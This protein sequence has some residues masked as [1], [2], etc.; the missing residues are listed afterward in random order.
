M[1]SARILRAYRSSS[2][3]ASMAAARSERAVTRLSP[4]EVVEV[5]SDPRD[6][7]VGGSACPSGG[8]AGDL[9]PEIVIEPV[10]V[11]LQHPVSDLRDD[12]RR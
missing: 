10:E 3:W 1:S 5:P 2:I 8:V 9:P 6:V 7:A 11:E 4:R 12:C